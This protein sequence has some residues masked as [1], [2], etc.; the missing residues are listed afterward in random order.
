MKNGGLAKSRKTSYD[1]P[2]PAEVDEDDRKSI[3]LDNNSR[4]LF[5]SCSCKVTGK[6]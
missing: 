3:V 5:D 6:G 4:T 1:R 2:E